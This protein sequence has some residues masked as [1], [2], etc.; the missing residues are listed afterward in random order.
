[1]FSERLRTLRK[2]KKMT[3]ED[4]AHIIGVGKSTI[5]SYESDLRRPKKETLIHLSDIFEVSTDYL[6]GL[7]D[8]RTRKEDSKDLSKLLS[9]PDYHYKGQQISKQDMDFLINYLDRISKLEEQKN[10]FKDSEESP[11]KHPQNT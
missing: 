7:S 9:E 10:Q 11:N 1:M 4:L 5:S 2:E 3:M 6:L 8:D